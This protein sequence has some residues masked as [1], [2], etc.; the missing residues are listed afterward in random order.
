MAALMSV[1]V[2]CIVNMLVNMLF[3][4]VNVGMLMLIVIMATHLNSPPFS[5]LYT[6]MKD[7]RAYNPF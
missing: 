5:V 7:D 6:S 1:L 3:T 4:I 2:L